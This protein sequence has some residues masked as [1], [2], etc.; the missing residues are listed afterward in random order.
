MNRGP[1]TVDISHYRAVVYGEQDTQTLLD[2]TFDAGAYKKFLED[3]VD[4]W[5]YYKVK[6]ALGVGEKEA[7]VIWD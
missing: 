2:S 4:E 6:H 5:A 3:Q 1:L 7:C